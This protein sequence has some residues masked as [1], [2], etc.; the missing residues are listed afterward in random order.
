MLLLH[1]QFNRDENVPTIFQRFPLMHKQ[2]S[3]KYAKFKDRVNKYAKKDRVNKHAKKDRVNK[4]AKKDR[5]NKHA[6]N[7]VN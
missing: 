6:E 3:N 5:V 2:R 1:C 7:R 4:H